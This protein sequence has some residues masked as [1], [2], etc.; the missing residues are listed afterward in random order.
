MRQAL[1][2]HAL[3]KFEAE[4]NIWQEA[5]DGLREIKSGG[6]KRVVL[7]PRSPRHCQLIRTDA[8]PGQGRGGL[9]SSFPQAARAGTVIS[10]QI[11]NLLFISCR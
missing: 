11:W 6:G 8:I 7:E 2:E 5:L 9:L 4:R 3:A 1:T 10:R